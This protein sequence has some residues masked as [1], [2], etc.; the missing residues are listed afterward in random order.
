M[1]RSDISPQAALSLLAA[2][3]T[4]ID[5]RAPVEFARGSLS[6]ATNLPIMNDDERSLVGHCYKTQGADAATELGYQ[7][8]SR[9]V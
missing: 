3:A 7:L 4:A 6:G 1:I 9:D 5:V 8:V 2:G